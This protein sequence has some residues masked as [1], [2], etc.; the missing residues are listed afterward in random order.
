MTEG[1]RAEAKAMVV[2]GSALQTRLLDAAK[3]HLGPGGDSALKDAA[4]HV[5]GVPLEQVAYAQLPALLS[6]VERD[7]LLVAGRQTA[8][9]IAEEL[10]RLHVDAE[11]GLS[12][13]LIGAVGK[14]LGPSAE[15]FL[16]NVCAKLKLHLETIDR[17][18]LPQLADAVRQDA[19]LL[20]GP[21]VAGQ[22]GQAVEE[23][24]GAR[25]VGLSKRVVEL[26]T[27]HAGAQGE[28]VMREL[29]HERL[30]IDLDDLDVDG[31]SL[32]ARAVERDGPAKFGALCAAK[33]VAAAKQATVSPADGLRQKV[34][35]LA[36]RSV[37]PAGPDFVKRSCAKAGVPFEAVDFEHVMWLA[38][39][40]RTEAAPLVGKK[41]ADE[42]ARAI[43]GFLTGKS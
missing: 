19:V 22:L 15:P 43:R 25:P 2:I 1:N 30:E 6:A 3:R 16:T 27:E 21:E 26:A 29:C 42:M 11:A 9:A 33:F 20:L 31:V 8:F 13:R 35:E 4:E 5:V 23:A 28:P 36:K 41:G 24:A 32:L 10:D 14:R 34:L 38:E 40:V 39:V 17:G 12:G 7:A 37:G 18:H